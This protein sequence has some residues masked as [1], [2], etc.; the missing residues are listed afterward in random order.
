MSKDKAKTDKHAG[1][2]PR[3]GERTSGV[4]DLTTT[5]G[6]QAIAQITFPKIYNNNQSGEID[7][8]KIKLLIN[9]YIS[10]NTIVKIDDKTGEEIVSCLPVSYVGLRIKLDNIEKC[11]YDL[12]LKGYVNQDDVDNDTIKCN[13]ALS[14]AMRTGDN[15]ITRYMAE[16]NGKYDMQRCIRFLE[17]KGE[18]APSKSVIDANIRTGG[19]TKDKK[20][21]KRSV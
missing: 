2:R 3:K 17:T 14:K 20:W 21:S 12:W 18:I 6:K 19:F 13:Y 4:Y 1:G 7:V 10:E 5:Q 8:N 11:T 9:E 16:Q 15:Y